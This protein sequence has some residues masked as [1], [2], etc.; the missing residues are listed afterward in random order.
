M[1]GTNDII[2]FS[3]SHRKHAYD[4][5]L[6]RTFPW[7]TNQTIQID[8]SNFNKVPNLWKWLPWGQGRQYELKF[9][10]S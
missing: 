4:A 9:L 3:C 6:R 10:A 5:W 7:I 1:H 2:I 8:R